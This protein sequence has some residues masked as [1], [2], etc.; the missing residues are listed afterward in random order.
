M[1]KSA[2]IAIYSKNNHNLRRVEDGGFIF[3]IRTYSGISSDCFVG[4]KI[5]I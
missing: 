5:N 4:C 3:S 1:G 2:Q